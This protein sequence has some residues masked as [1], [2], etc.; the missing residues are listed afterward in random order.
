VGSHIK[1]IESSNANILFHC[2]GREISFTPIVAANISVEPLNEEER[3][4]ENTLRLSALQKNETAKVVAISQECRGENRR[5]LLDLGILPDTKIEID[6]E[7]PLQD[8][9]AYRVRNTSIALRNSL[10]DLVLIKKINT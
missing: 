7:S 3:Y 6:L 2:E 8:P 10:A 9:I 4:E 1:I 5:R